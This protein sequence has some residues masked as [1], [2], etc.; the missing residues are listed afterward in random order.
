[1]LIVWMWLLGGC[2]SC[3]EVDAIRRGRDARSREC[4]LNKAAASFELHFM[5]LE[6]GSIREK[7]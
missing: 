7:A 4:G 3:L 6:V 5:V 2:W 1:V